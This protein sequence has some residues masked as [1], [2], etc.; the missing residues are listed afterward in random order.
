MFN[1]PDGYQY[2]ELRLCL[3]QIKPYIPGKPVEEVERE[4]GITGAIKLASNENPLGASPLALES[5]QRH[6]HGIHYYPDG[7][8]HYLKQALANKLG[9]EKE[10][11]VLGNGSDELLSLL[12]QAYLNPGEEAIA[13]YPTFSEYEFAVR[14]AGGAV[15]HIP[16]EKETFEY[17][18]ETILSR[19]TDRTRL[20]FI[21]SPNN[22]TGTV[23]GRQKMLRFVEHL[24]PR[25]LAVL[26]EAYIE[27][28][29][30]PDHEGSLDF[31]RR[32]LPVIVLRTFSKIYGLAGLRIGYAIAPEKIASD[33]NRIREPFNVNLLAQAAA[34]AALN[35][36]QHLQ[37]SRSLVQAGKQQLVRGLGEMGF[38]P[39][40]TQAN[41]LFVDVKVDSRK[42]FEGLLRLGVIIRSGDIFGFPTFIRVTVGTEEQ[43]RR[44]LEALA[45]VLK[46]LSRSYG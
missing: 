39:V 40:P 21:C 34:L 36:K 29:D 6:I 43:N 30:D 20:V 38:A 13:V 25:L 31:I 19:L 22:P 1:M 46:G 10:Q 42:V 23:V 16:L 7:S 45:K 4:L 8:G 32:Q 17:N 28:A 2:P 3:Q 5:M 44:F 37:S 41:F 15:K 24:P 26:D 11:V 35:D 12:A 14:K 9:V 18:L 27:Y 33:L